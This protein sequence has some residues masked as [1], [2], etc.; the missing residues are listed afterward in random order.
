MPPVFYNPPVLPPV[1]Q[2]KPGLVLPPATTNPLPIPK[3]AGGYDKSGR[4]YTSEPEH[5]LG[6][7]NSSELKDWAST[8]GKLG[9]PDLVTHI[10]VTANGLLDEADEAAAAG[11]LSKAAQLQARAQYYVDAHSPRGDAEKAAYEKALRLEQ[12]KER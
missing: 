10:Y 11:D 8:Y 7:E 1:P 4:R 12:P 2:A 3:V 6:V 5:I 9:T